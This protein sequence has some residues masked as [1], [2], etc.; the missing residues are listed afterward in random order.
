MKQI[1][2]VMVFLLKLTSLTSAKEWIK[3]PTRYEYLVLS[4]ESMELSFEEAES[5]CREEGGFLPRIDSEFPFL[6]QRLGVEKYW[7]PVLPKWLSYGIKYL[8]PDGTPSGINSESPHCRRYPNEC[9]VYVERSY[10]YSYPAHMKL[11]ASHVCQRRL[12]AENRSLSGIKGIEY[13][14]IDSPMNFAEA[15]LACQTNERSLPY[16]VDPEALRFVTAMIGYDHTYW[17]GADYSAD[18]VSYQWVDNAAINNNIAKSDDCK[19]YLEECYVAS[20]T[21]ELTVLPHYQEL[22]IVVC[23]S[24]SS[25]FKY[26]DEDIPFTINNM[27][28]SMTA[29]A[30]SVSRQARNT[31]KSVKDQVQ[32]ITQH[33]DKT[34]GQKWH[35]SI[36]KEH[37]VLLTTRSRRIDKNFIQFIVDGAVI[38]MFQSFAKV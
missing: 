19:G 24:Y 8:W 16:F 7:I 18:E 28:T 38:T 13:F 6:Q 12:P 3:G 14:L 25:T 23:A 22:S 2:L 37:E 29:E 34:Y 1:H 21:G 10:L 9:A 17:T 36:Y 26:H 11:S 20:N 4:K 27:P 31:F 35:C 5:S 30:V 32:L 15:K 33:F